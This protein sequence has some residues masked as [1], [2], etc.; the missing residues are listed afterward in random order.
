MA[1]MVK[2][3][4]LE[5]TDELKDVTSLPE[6]KKIGVNNIAIY[7]VTPEY[8]EKGFICLAHVDTVIGKLNCFIREAQCHPGSFE[9]VSAGPTISNPVQAQVLRFLESHVER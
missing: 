7:A 2:V 5:E 6:N 9:I 1:K 3:W 4:Y 8:K